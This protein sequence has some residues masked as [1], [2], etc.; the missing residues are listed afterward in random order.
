MIDEADLAIE[1]GGGHDGRA[2]DASDRFESLG[3]DHFQVVDSEEWGILEMLSGRGEERGG[4]AFS[5]AEEGAG[6]LECA[7]D[8]GS[9][10][11][12]F[13]EES[14]I[15]GGHRQAIVLADRRVRDDV[16]GE[17]EVADHPANDGELLN[18][19][20]AEYGRIGLEEIE[21]FEYDCADAVE[22]SGASRTAELPGEQ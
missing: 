5:A 19:F 18:I 11:P 6:G 4:V 13:G 2:L 20:F 1:D 22:M 8:S 21:E 9:I 16:D 7:M 10:R 15:A 3:I 17:I 12:V 14:H